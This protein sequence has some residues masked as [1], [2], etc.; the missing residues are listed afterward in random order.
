MNRPTPI[1]QALDIRPEMQQVD[2]AAVAAQPTMTKALVLCQNLSGLDDKMFYGPKGVV[3]SQ[4]QWSRIMGSG[5]HNFPQ[6]GLNL[7]M[8]IAGNEVP[9]LWMLHSRG[10]DIS[11]LRKRETET[12]RK[13]RMAEERIR[14]LEKEA[15]IKADF[16]A[17]ALGR[18]VA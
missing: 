8:D 6:N 10:Y 9:L 11:S 3:T 17:E 14:E 18:R 1:Q 5:Q 12:E 15:Q 16:V 2:M 7:F 13:L 4:A